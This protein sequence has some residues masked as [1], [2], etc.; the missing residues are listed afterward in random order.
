M[1]QYTMKSYVLAAAMLA[2]FAMYAEPVV[3]TDAVTAAENWIA[4][5][6]A[7]GTELS[8]QAVGAQT[9]MD[10]DGEEAVHVVSMDGGGFVVTST[11]DEMEP[12]L[13]YSGTG[14]FNVDPGS[15]L[16]ALLDADVRARK[17]DITQGGNGGGLRLMSS[18]VAAVS[19]TGEE[20]DDSKSKW[21]RLLGRT[22]RTRNIRLMASSGLS[23]VSTVCVAPLIQ[24]KWDQESIG[25]VFKDKCYNYYTPNGYPCG[26]VATAMAQVMRYYQYP[27]SD[28]S[29][30]TVKCKVDGVSQSLKMKGGCY[31]WSN[32]P[33]DPSSGATATQREAIGKLTYDCGV[34]VGMDYA[35]RGS[36]ASMSKVPK[37]LKDCF[38]YHSASVTS[39]SKSRATSELNE[40][41]PVLLGINT[42]GSSVGH[43]VVADGYGYSSDNTCYFHLNMGWAGSYDLWYNMPYVRDYDEVHS[44]VCNIKPTSNWQ[45][46]WTVTL[47]RQGGS[48]GSASVTATY[49]SAMPTID[50]P[51][52]SG[53]TFGGYYTSTGGS[54]TQYYTADG[55]SARTWDK[56]GATTL[57]AKWTAKT[58]SLATAVDNT[59]LVFTTGGDADWYGQVDMTHDG[60]DAARSGEIGN[61][62]YTWMRTTV[63]GSG[64]ISF[65]WKCDTGNNWLMAWR[66]IVAFKIDDKTISTIY[67][68]KDWRM[69][70]ASVKGSGTHTIDWIYTK[71]NHGAA[72]DRDD[73]AWVD[74]VEWKPMVMVTLDAQG[75]TVASNELFLARN[76][77]NGYGYNVLPTPTWANRTFLGWYTA[78]V[79]GTRVYYSSTTPS[80]DM[81][82][83]AHWQEISYS[84]WDYDMGDNYK[85]GG[86]AKWTHDSTMSY[87]GS[88]AFKSGAIGHGNTNWLERTVNGPG[89]LKFYWKSSSE[90]NCDICAFSIDGVENIRVSGISS[91]WS[92]IDRTISE[93]GSHTLR[94]TYSKN[95]NTV[96][97]SDCVWVDGITWQPLVSIT[98]DGNGGKFYNYLTT[99]EITKY[100]GESFPSYTSSPTRTGY[101]FD[102]WFT[103]RN[104]GVRVD[105]NTIVSA[106]LSMLYA[107]WLKEE[108]LADILD[109]T[110][111]VITGGATS[112]FG[113]TSVS[114]GNIGSACSGHLSYGESNWMEI[115]TEGSGRFRFSWAIDG[116][117]YLSDYKS[118]TDAYL[119]TLSFTTNGIEAARLVG[120]QDWTNCTFIVGDGTHKFRWLYSKKWPSSVG[121]DCA[122]VD[123]VVWEPEAW[124]FFNPEGGALSQTSFRGYV[125]DEVVLPMP[126]RDGY[127][128]EGWFTEQDGGEKIDGASFVLDRTRW[129][130][131]RWS[132]TG[133]SARDFENLAIYLAWGLSPEAALYSVYRATTD[134]WT[135]ANWLLGSDRT[136]RYYFDYAATPGVDYWYWVAALDDDGNW[137]YSE[138]VKGLREVSLSLGAYEKNHG[139]AS[140]S[141]SVSVT[142]NTSWK[143]VTADTWIKLTTSNGAGN[144]SLAYTVQ[145]NFSPAARTGYITVTAGGDTAN[146]KTETILVEQSGVSG[147]DW[148]AVRGGTTAWTTKKAQTKKG[149][150]YSAT[151]GEV[152][153]SVVLKLGTVNSKKKA[154][155]SGTVYHV[156][157]KK[158]AV[159]AKTV[160]VKTGAPTVVKLNVKTLGTLEVALGGDGFFGLIGKKYVVQTARVGGSNPPANIG[161]DFGDGA[162][163]PANTI[164]DLLP[165]NAEIGVANGKWTCGASGVKTTKLSNGAYRLTYDEYA[166]NPASMKLTYT[167]STGVFKGS[168][169]IYTGTAAKAKYKTVTVTGVF[170]DDAGVGRAKL[171][172][173]AATWKVFVE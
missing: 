29:P 115:T 81:T 171:K 42:K 118:I 86:D 67:D 39:W 1:K 103:A 20:A 160:A 108:P 172:K 158:Y 173:P 71:D 36:S 3:L 10:D 53:Y 24:S 38:K 11:D 30:Q 162:K 97:G 156:N 104:G 144:G 25:L 135:G 44:L 77:Y 4:S 13:A 88:Y 129:L 89:R 41:R 75:G 27:T 90:A 34:A 96:K 91:D 107:H 63:D 112:W 57:Y 93:T 16:A 114:H 102:G 140:A 14:T 95:G 52:R 146:P 111:A 33:R 127:K 23:T 154:K 76:D 26:C 68:T 49:G 150:I 60:V 65:W 161:V 83:Y 94:W 121:A 15:P 145:R 70:T 9:Y 28:I 19:A 87:S 125:G 101:R 124:I 105:A 37:A 31:D 149:A 100:A 66:D 7:M 137:A 59:A 142:A 5:G 6:E 62:K 155:V 45:K 35:S 43:A 58:I 92:S 79:G 134:D 69:V 122:W 147:L 51:T 139:T 130:Y 123:D 8:A 133:V 48:G 164:V 126:V 113:Q 141:A 132:F 72:K 138:A 153:G 131:A 98:L 157:G 22:R 116:Y 152:L 54:G 78:K 136:W 110:L 117:E 169:R 32:M 99:Q 159:T 17:A 143:A 82:L 74:Q 168:F 56:T 163:L 151:S 64:I 2:Q 80:Q 128:F 21:D 166:W 46:T 170:V 73:C 109:T 119:D 148:L 40:Y 84:L 167:A 55:T 47:D 50:V 85:T 165:F 120:Q 12:I 18:S 106:D 61:S